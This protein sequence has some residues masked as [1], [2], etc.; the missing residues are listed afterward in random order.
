[1]FKKHNK[2]Q[3]K[4]KQVNKKQV[5]KKRGKLADKLDMYDMIFANLYAGNAVVEPEHT[6]DRQHIDI[7]FSNIASEKLIIKYFVIRK[8]PDWMYPR[9]FDRIR[10]NCLRPG[11]R[12]NFFIY[13][14]PHEI[15]WESP[16]MKNRMSIWK[17][18]SNEEQSDSAFDYRKNRQDMLAKLRIVESTSYLNEAELDQKR[19]LVAASFVIEVAC[20]RDD[21]S[22]SYMA[23][24]IEELKRMCKYEDIELL[25][26]RVNMMDW[27]QQLGT[28]SLRYIKEV[29]RRI[30]KK[31]MTDDVLANFNSYKQGRIGTEGTPLGIDI[32]SHTPVIKKFKQDP[33]GAENVLIAGGTGSG[34]S[35]FIKQLIPWLLLDNVVTVLDFEGD[36][37]TNIER[38]IYGGNPKDAILI[39]M[40]KGS[41]YYF[42]P[43]EIGELTGESEID[44][45]LKE[46][47][48]GYIIAM[49]KTI[50]C[51]DNNELD[52]WESSVL[53]EAIMRVYEDYGVTDD[54]STWKRSK[55]LR[56]S[57]IY[58]EICNMVISQEFLDDNMDDVKH[59]AAVNIREVCKSYFEEGEPKYGA[60]KN[61]INIEDIRDCRFIVFSFGVNGATASQMD[62][63]I[64][65]LKQLSVANI[66][67][68]ISNYCKYARKCYN[69]KIWE[70]Y[71]RWSEIK[72]SSEIIANAMTGGRKR[73]D[74][75]FIITNDLA[76][77]I[78]AQ[79]LLSAKLQQNITG[80]IIGSVSSDPI[81]E[82]FCKTFN[83]PEMIEPLKMID[84]A[85]SRKRRG[86]TPEDD[87]CHSFCVVM[88]NTGERAVVKAMLPEV[89][90]E[91]KL[92]RTGVER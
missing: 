67:S 40:G 49:F 45:G 2:K 7:G 34:K 87:Y 66:T 15:N 84:K 9:L 26:L 86:S 46:Q 23:I 91:S 88:L 12:I 31:I 41:G 58:D 19:S 27:I 28:F 72:G 77:M 80:Y 76:N 65:A 8:F 5:V 29:S 47:A 53:D 13:G 56:I 4:S 54:K 78:D 3:D 25:E 83:I 22:L 20:V 16:E 68:Q 85:K 75:N 64:L 6:L 79:D 18:Y 35:L 32:W 70:E 36:E 60:F 90:L 57:M 89:L 81:R 43:M 11:I 42:D 37:Y 62:S 39:S 92:F 50:L 51:K 55:G 71:Q 1:M 44:D 10:A 24:A 38:L 30:G 33:D 14:E 73:G 61:P 59:K 63:K 21:L 52:K 17:S 69:V 48:Q 74:I 82:K